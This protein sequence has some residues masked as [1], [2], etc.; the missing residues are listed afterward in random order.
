MLAV[1]LPKTTMKKKK[2]I[3]ILVLLISSLILI[4]IY[5]NQIFLK[6]IT[7]SARIIGKEKSVKIYT[8]GELNQNIKLFSVTT[9]FN[10]KPANYDLLVFN[11][12]VSRNVISI[13]YDNNYIGLPTS[14]N[15]KDYKIIYGNL[16][17]SDMGG[18]FTP[19]NDA[20]KG[21]D[22]EPELNIKGKT[23]KFNLPSDQFKIDSIRIE[24]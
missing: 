13:N 12:K 19:I 7:N 4:F 24:K 15:E 2:V 5:Q 9:Y 21:F 11:E 17:Q 8:N 14:T 10:G 3:L 1:I 6:Y 16:I 22:F 20:F 23:I 18:K